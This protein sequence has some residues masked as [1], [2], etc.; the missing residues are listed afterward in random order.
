MTRQHAS[1]YAKPADLYAAHRCECGHIV[2][3][4]QKSGDPCLFH[5][6]GCPCTDHRCKEVSNDG[7]ADA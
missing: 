4:G 1:S 3:R 2:Y 5:G 7:V 6:D